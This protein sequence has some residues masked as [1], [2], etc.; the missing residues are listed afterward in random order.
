MGNPHDA[1][2]GWLRIIGNILGCAE[3]LWTAY[4]STRLYLGEKTFLGDAFD[5]FHQHPEHLT[6]I[7]LALAGGGAI[8]LI[9]LNWVAVS[10]LRRRMQRRSPAARLRLLSGAL[11]GELER[12]SSPSFLYS[13]ARQFV[14]RETINRQLRRLGIR[15]PDPDAS[16]RLYSMFIASLIPIARDGDVASARSMAEQF[17]NEITTR[18]DSEIP[19]T[20][21]R[22]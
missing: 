19:R 3:L 7:Y 5:V 12:L 10:E 2:M 4:E 21:L 16:N 22:K 9:Q 14:E 8:F 13:D 11:E 6:G 20:Q 18:K 1:R 17:L 15:T